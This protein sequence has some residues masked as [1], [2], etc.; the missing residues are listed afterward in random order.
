MRKRGTKKKRERT[1][2][3]DG[4]LRYL[5]RLPS[6][7]RSRLTG[8]NRYRSPR[9]SVS[10]H[11][12][13][14]SPHYIFTVSQHARVFPSIFRHPPRRRPL[15]IRPCLDPRREISGARLNNRAWRAFNRYGPPLPSPFSSR[16]PASFHPRGA[17]SSRIG[18]ACF[19]S[20][21]DFLPSPLPPRIPRARLHFSSRGCCS[22]LLG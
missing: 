15:P 16:P 4:D 2:E 1:G 17:I 8:R 13:L 21:R 3:G 11:T 5:L 22:G 10:R 9:S 12:L 20:P 6:L 14:S 7:N 18:F 19:L